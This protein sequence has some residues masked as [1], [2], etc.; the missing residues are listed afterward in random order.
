MCLP[1]SHSH[2]GGSSA[3]PIRDAN[4][5]P[6]IN[7]PMALLLQIGNKWRNLVPINRGSSYGGSFTGRI[8]GKLQKRCLK[9]LFLS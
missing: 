1:L 6:S 7:T 8:V 3:G 2:S 9:E 5:V 4:G